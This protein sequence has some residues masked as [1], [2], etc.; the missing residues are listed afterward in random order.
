M[1][2]PSTNDDVMVV[3]DYKTLEENDTYAGALMQFLKHGKVPEEGKI[4]LKL[5]KDKDSFFLGD[6][7]CVYRR[8]MPKRGRTRE[9]F[10]VPKSMVGKLLENSHDI[11]ISAHPRFIGHARRSSNLTSGLL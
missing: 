3:I 11:P 5:G 4:A 9:Q 1:E 10:V 2:S 6:D 7:G 8:I